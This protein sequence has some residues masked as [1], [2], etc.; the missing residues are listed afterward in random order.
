MEPES[1]PY[2]FKISLR[3][4]H[5]SAD[6]SSCS[7]E[8]ELEPSRRWKVGE[9]R[10]TPRGNRLEGR[11][12]ES[13]WTSP[14]D[15]SAYS[16]LEDALTEVARRLTNHSFFFAKHAESGGTASL[17]VGLFLESF[18][19]GFLLEPELLA[20]YSSLGVALE[21]DM[22]GSDEEPARP[23]NSFNPNSLRGSA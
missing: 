13:Y 7:G 10:T 1:R 11:R 21:F 8:F 2:R 20:E 14:L 3:F 15:I 17:F 5:P 4:V 6:L 12:H 23:N 9:P 19:T 18:N 16:R 22:Y